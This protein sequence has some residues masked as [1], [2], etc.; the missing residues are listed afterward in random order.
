MLIFL[1]WTGIP[2]DLQQTKRWASSY[3]ILG[4]IWVVFIIVKFL[5]GFYFCQCMRNAKHILVLL[6]WFLAGWSTRGIITWMDKNE[7]PSYLHYSDITVALMICDIQ[8]FYS[9]LLL[10]LIKNPEWIL[11]F[12]FFLILLYFF[13]IFSFPIYKSFTLNLYSLWASFHFLYKCSTQIP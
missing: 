5:F 9:F 3:K 4:V 1:V 11:L 12:C 6:L 13:L 7:Q 10:I 8:F 2:G